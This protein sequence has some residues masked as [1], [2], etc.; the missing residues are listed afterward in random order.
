MS[1]TEVH[2]SDHAG[3]LEAAAFHNQLRRLES[4]QMLMTQGS[5]VVSEV[6]QFIVRAREELS[7]F[8]REQMSYADAQRDVV[9]EK[10][11]L[12]LRVAELETAAE[13]ADGRVR[14]QN[15]LLEALR[16][17]VAAAAEDDEKSALA[18]QCRTAEEKLTLA[19]QKVSELEASL[20]SER[21][22][23]N[24]SVNRS[25]QE[26]IAM[27]GNE[28]SL[29]KSRLSAVETQLETERERRARLMEV[30]KAHDVVSSRS[31]VLENQGAQ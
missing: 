5:A 7:V 31:A 9:E 26:Q 1:P 22:Q 20:R 27:H 3:R 12:L 25:R 8:H 29:L 10:A 16:A 19:L 4:L 2:V 17:R 11:S 23:K 28:I 13:A 24:H 14:E 6:A 18:A 30:V 15:V 21:E